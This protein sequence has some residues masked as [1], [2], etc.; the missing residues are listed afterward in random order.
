MRIGERGQAML[1]VAVFFVFASLSLAVGMTAPLHQEVQNAST[2][3]SSK[4]GYFVAEGATEDVVYRLRSGKQLDALETITLD[5]MS[6]TASI[7]DDGEEKR[8]LTSGSSGKHTRKIKTTVRVGSGA[9]FFYGIQTAEGGFSIQNTALVLGN[10]FSNGTIEGSNLNLVLGSAVSAG[11]NG[12]IDGLNLTEDA[13]AKTIRDSFVGDDAYYQTLQ[14]SLVLGTKHP[15]SAPQATSSLPISDELI[16]EWKTAAQDGGTV[17]SPCPYIIT[18]SVTL[19]PKKIN[20]DLEVSGSGSLRLSG[21]LWIVGDIT[22][23]NTSSIRADASIGNTSVALIADDPADRLTS[24]KIT[25]QNSAQFYGNGGDKSYVMVLSQNR[26]AEQGGSE[27]AIVMQNSVSGEVILYA[28]H[29]LI[30]IQNSV[31]LKEVAGYRVVLKNSAAISY[32][33]GLADLVFTSGPSAGYE[34][35]EWEES[36]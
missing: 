2:L 21:P 7:T 14:S 15:G 8:I 16:E 35:D 4:S 31:N 10:L 6:A 28:G 22:I 24:S 11:P 9:S 29:G 25:L 27:K 18:T 32:D 19:G 33:S 12:L 1:G 23:K 36:E 34:I 30:E 5:D 17:S 3:V 13:Y 26:S 20:C